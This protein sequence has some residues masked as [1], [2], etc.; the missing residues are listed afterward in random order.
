MKMKN[1]LMILVTLAVVFAMAGAVSGDYGY[2]GFDDIDSD[3]DTMIVNYTVLDS[4]TVTIPPYVTIVKNGD[5]FNSTGEVNATDVL[6]NPDKKL[7]VN[8]TSTHYING[9]YYLVCD[10]DSWI[11]Y[12]I[13]VTPFGGRSDQVINNNPVL[14]VNAGA[15]HPNLSN[16]YGFKKIG[17]LAT[18]TF[19]TTQELINNATKSGNHEDK[20]TFELN[21]IPQPV[22]Q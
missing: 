21:V 8:L 1:V 6:I 19:E 15:G 22:R 14:T 13:N 18:L 2:T 4:Y 7:V 20:L 12:Y 5:K 16:N 17:G 3:S 11:C 9:E 10:E